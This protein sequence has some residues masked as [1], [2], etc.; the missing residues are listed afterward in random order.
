LSSDGE[1]NVIEASDTFIRVCLNCGKGYH[2]NNTR[3]P[4]CDSLD[5]CRAHEAEHVEV[6]VEV[7][8]NYQH[9]NEAQA[10]ALF[11][12]IQRLTG[13]R[14]AK[15]RLWFQLQNPLLG[16]VSPEWMLMNG[17]GDRLEKF[18]REAE[19]HKVT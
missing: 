4:R 1:G 2:N 19:E 9:P 17:R 18:V 16:N 7:P 15:V 13:W 6:N 8:D 14:E 12:R 10:R 11:T 3:C 5:T